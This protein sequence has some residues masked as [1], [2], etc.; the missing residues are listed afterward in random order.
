VVGSWPQT[1]NRKEKK[2]ATQKNRPQTW[3]KYVGYDLK[4]ENLKE[5]ERTAGIGI[6]RLGITRLLLGVALLR[7]TIALL[8]LSILRLRVL[9]SVLVSHFFF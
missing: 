9:G 8:R 1:K 6:D 4:R 5:W 7:L 2:N 3:K